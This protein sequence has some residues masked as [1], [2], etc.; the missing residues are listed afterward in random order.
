MADSILEFWTPERLRAAR[1][2]APPRPFK[3]P[4]PARAQTAPA[5]AGEPILVPQGELPRFPFQSIGRL[6]FWKNSAPYTG[7]ASFVVP[8]P[9]AIVTSAHN[10]ISGNGVAQ[11]ILFIPAMINS[12]D[13]NGQLFG[14]FPQIAGGQGWHGLLT[15]NGILRTRTGLTTSASCSWDPEPTAGPS[16]RS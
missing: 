9:N 5:V 7:S 6:F 12:G 2:E 13:I 11:N 1:P 4:V 15:G 10:L 8:D 3:R 14:V 16:V